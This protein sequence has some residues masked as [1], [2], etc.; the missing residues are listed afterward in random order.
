MVGATDALIAYRTN[1]HVDQQ[2]RGLEA[3]RLMARTLAKEIEPRQAAEFPPLAINIECQE[4]GVPPLLPI[5]E[6]AATLQKHP[7]V[8]STSIGL[9]FPY[10][11][12]VEMGASAIVVTNGDQSLA[13]TKVRELAEVMWNARQ[14]FVPRLTSIDE[15]LAGAAPL[16]G[17]S[18]LPKGGTSAPVCLL[19]MGDNV[20]GGSPGDGTHIAH[21]L[22]RRQI[23]DAFVCLCDP[24]AVEAAIRVQFGKPAELCVG[25]KTDA[26]HG[27]PLAATFTVIAKSAGQF[28]E[29]QPRHGGFSKF[30]QGLTA[31]VRTE[32]GL[33][34]MLTSR[35]M[36]PWS[37]EQL[38]HCGLNPA[39]FRVLVAKGV[40]APVAA[41]REVC[42]TF[43]RVDTPG[44]TSAN[45]SRF[46]YQNRRRPM[47]PFEPE[48]VWSQPFAENRK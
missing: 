37:L 30:D 36:A 29:S 33:T 42:K 44:V 25:G 4:T 20:G 1:P 48:A 6:A 13:E 27:P 39:E 11:D 43:I 16:R 19:D 41:Y 8:L 17:T 3:A 31:V 34:I 9:G 26:R 5:Y 28:T 35:R 14:T 2:E 47:Y 38:R 15:A 45:L 10:A 40:H 22:H 32:S 21:A 7:H 12:V 23:A 46:E 18:S 24:A